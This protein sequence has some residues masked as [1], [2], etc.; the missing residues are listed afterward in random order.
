MYAASGQ[1]FVIKNKRMQ[2]VPNQIRWALLFSAFRTLGGVG[3][4]FCV[5]SV[6]DCQTYG[7]SKNDESSSKYQ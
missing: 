3:G 4:N 1:I 6:F 7:D 5:L 2:L